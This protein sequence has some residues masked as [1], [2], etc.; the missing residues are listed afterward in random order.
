MPTN[1]TNEP[2]VEAE[3]APT[4]ADLAN[5]A[6]RTASPTAKNTKLPLIIVIVVVALVL[7]VGLFFLIRSLTTKSPAKNPETAYYENRDESQ[8]YSL[9]RDPETGERQLF[10]S[11]ETKDNSGEAFVE[12]QA[13][14]AASSDTTA[15]E[16]F[17]AKLLTAVYYVAVGQYDEAQSILDELRQS[18]LTEDQKTRVEKVSGDLASAR[19]GN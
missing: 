7:C 13:A 8:T 17:D 16:A 5:S 9:E 6:K 18:S 14:V 19:S 15:A 10:G 1:T 2:I 11:D 4:V 12:Y 3:A